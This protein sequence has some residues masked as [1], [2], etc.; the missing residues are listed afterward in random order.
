MLRTKSSGLET[1]MVEIKTWQ[2][3]HVGVVVVSYRIVIT[4][5]FR[6]LFQTTEIVKEEEMLSIL[7]SQVMI[8]VDEQNN[9]KSL[10]LGWF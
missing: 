10:L 1:K 9:Q 6:L 3:S 8:R 2:F 7:A 4:I 5:L